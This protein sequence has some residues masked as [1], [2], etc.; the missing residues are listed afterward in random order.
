[1]DHI[2]NSPA[3]RALEIL[4][5]DAVVAVIAFTGSAIYSNLLILNEVIQ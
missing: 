5:V 2:L 4:V 3:T 1:M